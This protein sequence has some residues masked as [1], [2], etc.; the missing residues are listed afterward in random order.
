[1]IR[2]RFLN[3]FCAYLAQVAKDIRFILGT[4]VEEQDKDI[5]IESS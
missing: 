4:W 2:L 1:M 5:H 3:A